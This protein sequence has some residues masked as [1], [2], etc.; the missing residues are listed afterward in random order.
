MYVMR[1]VRL[2]GP[3]W[4]YYV[5]RFWFWAILVNAHINTGFSRV[6][7]IWHGSSFCVT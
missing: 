5:G 1:F 6:F 3:F 7:H 4:I 2:C